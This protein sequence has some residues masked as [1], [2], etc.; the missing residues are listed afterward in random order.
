MNDCKDHYERHGNTERSREV[1]HVHNSSGEKETFLFDAMTDTVSR[2]HS[3]I[4]ILR[5][6]CRE[7]EMEGARSSKLLVL[8]S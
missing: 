5:D 3:H 8:T 2:K 6:M 7:Q 4:L 1:D